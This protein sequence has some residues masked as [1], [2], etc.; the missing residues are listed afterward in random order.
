MRLRPRVFSLVIAI[1]VISVLAMAIPVYWYTRSALE[2]EFDHQLR[3][4]VELAS[5]V[6]PGDLLANLIREPA[7]ESVR[8]AIEGELAELV[9]VGI[10][11]LAIY[12]GNGNELA[13]WENGLTTPPTPL[14]TAVISDVGDSTQSVVSEIYQLGEDNYFKAAAATIGGNTEHRA[15]LVVWGGAH[16]ISSMVQLIGSLFWIILF[17][18]FA[19]ISLAIIFSRSLDFSPYTPRSLRA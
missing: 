19:S 1:L 6:I 15:V 2:D 13:K 18:L 9:T 10:S 5:Q 7:L 4:Y 8:R 12:T 3:N 17:A 16:F 14:L 11:G